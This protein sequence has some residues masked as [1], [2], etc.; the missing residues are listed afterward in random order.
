MQ[1]NK[2][3]FI[4]SIIITAVITCIISVFFTYQVT[5]TKPAEED[6]TAQET[7]LYQLSIEDAVFAEES[8]IM[9]VIE[10]TE[11]SEDVIWDEQKERVLMATFHHYP[12]SYPDGEEVTLEWGTVWTFSQQEFADWLASQD[13]E[14]TDWSLRMNQLL[15]MPEDSGNTYVTTMWVSPDDM[16][17][18][19]YVPDITAQMTNT[20]DE[21]TMEDEAFV[22]WFEGNIIGSYFDGAYPWTRL[23][24]TYDWAD[25]GVEYGMSEFLVEQNAKVLVEKTLPLKEFVKMAA[26]K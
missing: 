6:Q 4:K 14:I 13:E 9:P 2:N 22:S 19:A 7:D 10:I 20:L 1:Y 16:I 26:G 11:D 3:T 24:Y 25:N 17:R 15:G 12:D 18:P 23:G 5:N 8:E 21:E